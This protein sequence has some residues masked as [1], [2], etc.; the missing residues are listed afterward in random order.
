M[1][2]FLGRKLQNM[3]L[4]YKIRQKN[5]TLLAD[6]IKYMPYFLLCFYF[7]ILFSYYSFLLLYTINKN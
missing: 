4:K 2:L 5:L 6:G 1:E 3:H 7:H